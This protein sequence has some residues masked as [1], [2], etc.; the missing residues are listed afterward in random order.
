MEGLSDLLGLAAITCEALLHGAALALTGFDLL[1]G[2]SCAWGHG[3]SL[4]P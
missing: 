2:I 4:T 1:F 3:Y